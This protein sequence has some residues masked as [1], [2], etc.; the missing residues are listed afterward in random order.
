LATRVAV[1][2]KV[3]SRTARRCA[4]IVSSHIFGTDQIYVK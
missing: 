2:S 3:A 1:V 4:S